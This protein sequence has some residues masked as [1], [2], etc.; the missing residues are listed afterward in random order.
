MQES[1]SNNINNFENISDDIN[2][3]QDSDNIVF[4]KSKDESI[5]KTNEVNNQESTD[6]SDYSPNVNY[7]NQ[8]YQE[9]LKGNSETIDSL[10]PFDS[11]RINF[12]E[13]VQYIDKGNFSISI[14]IEVDKINFSSLNKIKSKIL[15]KYVIASNNYNISRLN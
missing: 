4:L 2:K 9:F 11:C 10:Y 14:P 15:I 3:A 8:L 1:L 5:I 6:L 13:K 12:N 7:L